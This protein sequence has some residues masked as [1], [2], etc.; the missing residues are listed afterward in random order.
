MILAAGRGKR[1]KE[2]TKETPK[3]LI[4]TKGK[5]LIEWHLEK[6]SATGFQDIVINICYLPTMIKNFVG[7]GSF[8]PAWFSQDEHKFVL[9]F[10]D[11]F[12]I[13]HC[14]EEA[15]YLHWSYAWLSG[16]GCDCVRCD[17]KHDGAWKYS[18]DLFDRNSEA[19]TARY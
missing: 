12:F 7:D 2:L 5:P 4:L 3:P 6:L 14:G 8:P 18:S 13:G 15:R 16:G 10:R 17:S 1:M 11:G 9:C 19:K